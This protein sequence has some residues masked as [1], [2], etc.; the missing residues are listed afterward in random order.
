ML[1]KTEKT[2][3]DL[4]IIGGGLVGASLACALS[5]SAPSLEIAIVEAYPFKTSDSEYQPAFDARSVALS[6]TSKQ[7][8]EGM[9]LWSSINKLGIAAIK[10]IHV[11]DR[12][13]AG[14]TRLNAADEN[15]EALGYVV[16]TRVIGQAL[17]D[18]LH[19]QQNVTLIAPAKLKNFE[20]NTESASAILETGIDHDVENKTLTAKLLVAADGGDSV[21]RRLS[22]VRIKQRN[23]EQSAII[24]NVATDK[25]HYN[26]A[27]ERFTDSG[28]LALLPMVATE[29]EANRFSL[30]WTINS[31]DTEE[32]MNW[33]NET[34]LL[35]LQQRFGLR[36]GQF[37]HA[38]ERHVYPLSLMR[39]QEHVRERLAIIGNAAHTLHP[40][41]GQG[42]NLGL[43][44]V[45][46]LSQV[47]IDAV[48][49]N[50][51]EN[52]DIGSLTVLK[53]YADWRR[54]DHVQT[55]MATDSLVRIFS[56]NF[57]PLAALRNLGLLVVDVIPP[58]KKV[59]ARHAM[60]FV[61]KLPRLSR[62]LK[63]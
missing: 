16:E 29:N 61:G 60:G 24:A 6:Y 18:A 46:A 2:D 15:V 38:S 34:F 19:K 7:V 1:N 57:L 31:A 26:Q 11:S 55:A 39:A 47:I 20:L 52:N 45:A 4:I 53:T 10:K 27:F 62:G 51:A 58:L 56:N 48:R 28:P 3:F 35:K 43:R 54:R 21:V 32:M 40:V 30:V 9:G 22:G 12:G 37:V 5:Q 44:D 17:F 33:D 13:H 8:F 50:D 41:A 59:F 63:L 42:F 25:A 49:S 23:Y 14:V 36:A